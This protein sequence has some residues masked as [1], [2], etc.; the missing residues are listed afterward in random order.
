[1]TL[2]S[3]K[4]NFTQEEKLLWEIVRE[5]VLLRQQMTALVNALTTTTTTT[6]T[7]PPS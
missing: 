6:T 7:T 3:K 1:M 5:L 2:P 4:S